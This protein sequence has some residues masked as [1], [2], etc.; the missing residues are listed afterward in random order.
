LKVAVAQPRLKLGDRDANLLSIGK[1]AAVFSRREVDI[2]CFPE[3]ATTGYALY[4]KWPK[5]AE[6]VPGP[7][8][9][10]L[11]KVAR[12]NGL[13]LIAGMPEKGEGKAIFDSAVL[14]N[15]RGD[16]SGVYRKVHLWD[17]ERTY[18]SR[19]DRFRV[20]RTELGTIGIGICY[21]LEFPEPTRVMAIAGAKLIFFPSA[22]PRSMRRQIR[23]YA[24]SRA[25]ENCVFLAFSNMS[26][27]EADQ[28][29]MGDSQITSPSCELLA[30]VKGANGS[31][32]A[33]V[34]FKDLEEQRI[35]LPYLEQLVPSSYV[36]ASVH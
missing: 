4:D 17:R 26:G 31:A 11:G 29:Y 2:A 20:F 33:E 27:R 15:P 28:T 3:L 9:D 34:D 6:P 18:F 19:G 14:L 24:K 12:D 21:D 25:A 32:I 8:T 13:Y 36:V 30:E 10:R 23:V 1:E 7:T 35:Q 5:F 16:I 22:Q